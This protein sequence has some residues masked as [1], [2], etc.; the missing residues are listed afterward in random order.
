MEEK[1]P[2]KEG[3][4]G[5]PREAKNKELKFRYININGNSEDK[6][7]MIWEAFYKDRE[8][9][10][11]V[12]LTET[13]K[14]V[15]SRG[16]LERIMKMRKIGEKKGG[17]LEI[18][19]EKDEQIIL[20]EKKSRSS[21][22]LEVEGKCYGKEVKI[23]LVYF[24]ANRNAIGKER[25]QKIKEELEQKIGNSEDKGLMILGDFNGHLELLEKER[26]TDENGRTVL[27]W[28][29][30]Y[31]LTLLNADEK[32]DGTYT[33]TRGNQKSAIDWVLMNKEMY[34]WCERM[35]IDE[36][37]EIL[38]CSDHNLISITLNIRKCDKN[39]FRKATWEE[40]E[41]YK[42]DKV[43]QWS[44]SLAQKDEVLGSNPG[45][46]DGVFVWLTILPNSSGWLHLPKGVGK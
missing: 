7:D 35:E 12:C 10:N 38:E 14:N 40:G 9:C 13:H 27:S 1:A 34:G 3:K 42:K 20:E 45:G 6:E 11:I 33:R 15:E 41:Y 19:M 2:R 21:D 36:N 22:I 31:N 5:K 23:I 46:A 17:G 16:N 25:N 30:N 29:G 26:R 37:K 18:R 28:L 8:A 32:C 4:K 24:D 44:E 43:A 39:K